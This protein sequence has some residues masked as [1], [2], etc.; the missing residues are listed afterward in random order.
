M[1]DCHQS[2]MTWAKI[3]KKGRIASCRDARFVRPH[4][5]QSRRDYSE[6]FTNLFLLL[7]LAIYRAICAKIVHVIQSIGRMYLIQ[8]I[9]L[10]VFENCKRMRTFA[11]SLRRIYRSIK[12]WANFKI[13]LGVFSGALQWSTG[14]SQILL[15]ITYKATKMSYGYV[16]M[17]V[18]Y[19]HLLHTAW[20]SCCKFLIGGQCESLCSGTATMESRFFLCLYVLCSLLLPEFVKKMNV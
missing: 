12:G 9:C 5:K 1:V 10:N 20:A 14:I 18:V 11:M 4:R 2:L 15:P 8:K 17:G 19:L 3:R 6:P 13:F 7:T 16:Y